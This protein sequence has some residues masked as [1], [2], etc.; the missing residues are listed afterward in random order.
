MPTKRLYL[1][2]GKGGVGKTL[3]S[4]A[5]T[6]HLINSG[7]KALFVDFETKSQNQ[8]CKQLS[9][10]QEHLELF[11]NFE[12]YVSSK[13]RSPLLAHW[14]MGNEFSRSLINAIP[15]MSYII[16]LGHLLYLLKEDNQ[17]IIVV[18]CP[19]SGHAMTM[20]ESLRNYRQIFNSG[21]LFN[22]IETMQDFLS[23]PNSLQILICHIPSQLSLSEGRELKNHLQGLD[24]NDVQMLLN[25]SLSLAICDQG[26]KLPSY[27]H[28]RIQLEEE[29]EQIYCTEWKVK[30][31]YLSDSND[32]EKIKSM[33]PY[34]KDLTT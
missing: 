25:S 4:L 16:Y 7:H 14:I 32:L 8:F 5:F 20:L 30:I 29:L 19:S 18:D 12:R 11:K 15:G 24:L 3:S 13:L 22:D 17:L 23:S 1:F 21:S 9:I 34:F 2:T 31:P 28:H 6:H 27:L 26:E 33:A 10:P